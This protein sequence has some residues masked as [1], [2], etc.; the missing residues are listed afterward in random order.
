M[1]NAAAINAIQVPPPSAYTVAGDGGILG[2][3]TLTWVSSIYWQHSIEVI[4]NWLELI[5]AGTLSAIETES[6]TN[7]GVDPYT[8]VIVSK[9]QWLH[10]YAAVLHLGKSVSLYA[11]DA[12]TFTPAGSGQTL[13]TGV[14]APNLVGTGTEVGVKTNFLGGRFSGEAAV[15]K[16][17]LTNVDVI[18]GNFPNGAT[19]VVP[20]GETVTEGFDGDIAFTLVP[21]WQLVGSFYDGNETNALTHSLVAQTFRNS[22]AFFTRYDFAHGPLRGL[23]FGGG[24]THIGGRMVADTGITDYA[25][26]FPA[27]G[28]IEAQEAALANGFVVY[29]PDKH[30]TIQV[31]CDNILNQAYPLGV[32]TASEVDPSP[33]MTWIV[34]VGYKF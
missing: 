4:P 24:V 27:T 6:V 25:P 17:S 20:I 26:G 2:P 9:H 18:G 10:R 12:T 7:I 16:F 1:N 21:G 30:W 3:K 31:N 23:G 14:T 22:W 11:L 19:Y 29:K 28:L 8:A 33:P 34:E 5:A 13:E 15:F 32:Q